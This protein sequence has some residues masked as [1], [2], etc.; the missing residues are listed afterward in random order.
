MT[1][2]TSYTSDK[3]RI[4]EHL[5]NTY[6]SKLCTVLTSCSRKIWS[7]KQLVKTVEMFFELDVAGS[8]DPSKS[9]FLKNYSM[10]YSK[11]KN[12]VLQSSNNHPRWRSA[13]L[14][15]KLY[16]SDPLSNASLERLF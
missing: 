10:F 13:I 1:K 7:F 15:N 14:V 5:L 2:R 11:I 6:L 16:L 4:K 12:N 3:A 8:F 9:T